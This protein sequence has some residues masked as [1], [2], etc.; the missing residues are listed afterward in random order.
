VETELANRFAPVVRRLP[1]SA[2]GAGPLRPE[3][4]IEQ[5][6]ELAVYYAPLE[7]VHSTASVILVDIAPDHVQMRNALLEWRLQ[8][9]SGVPIA[10]ATAAAQAAVG[11]AEA[12]RNNLTAMLD[13][14][15]L[16]HLLG[17]DSCSSLFD[18]PFIHFTSLLRFPVFRSGMNSSGTPNMVRNSLLSR[19]LM[20]YF[21]PEALSLPNALF[22][23]LRPKVSE[24]FQHLI[25][26]N[27]LKSE[28]V[29]SGLENPSSGNR[30]RIAY[31][32]G[33]KPKAQLSHQASA[34]RIDRTTAELKT[35][36]TRLMN[37]G[38]KPVPQP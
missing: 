25:E 4:M 20:Q 29:L 19:Y 30:E 22:L 35:K 13:S 3:L 26:R 34:L 24:V 6:R 31:M 11:L 9:D 16:N 18:S 5:R 27:I 8:L 1:M 28:H 37:Q 7:H 14:L 32:L 2:F 36:I 23:P 21:V 10:Q 38:W 15:Q 33:R 17:V 12:T